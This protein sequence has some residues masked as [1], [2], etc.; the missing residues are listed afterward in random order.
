M[1]CDFLAIVASSSP[2][3]R[4]FSTGSDL[5]TK[6]RNRLSGKRIRQIL[7]LRA[8][9]VVIELEEDG[10]EADNEADDSDD[11]ALLDR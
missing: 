8:W 9:G 11:E 2:S 5:I 7:C 6:K 4:L 3:E 10:N 1:A